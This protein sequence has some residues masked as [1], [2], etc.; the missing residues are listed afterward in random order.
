[1]VVLYT[2]NIQYYSNKSRMAELKCFEIVS[3][4]VCHDIYIVFRQTYYQE[5]NAYFTAILKLNPTIV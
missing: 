3:F 5:E 4:K 2:Q 1:M